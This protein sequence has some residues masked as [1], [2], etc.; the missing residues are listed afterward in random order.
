MIVAGGTGLILKHCGC[1]VQ[2]HSSF[3]DKLLAELL[4]REVLLNAIDKGCN[5]IDIVFKI[6]TLSQTPKRYKVG[7]DL[8][9]LFTFLTC[10]IGGIILI[11]R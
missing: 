1:L 7:A 9:K 10:D 2:E 5:L 6:L 8:D 11:A 4:Y 3:I